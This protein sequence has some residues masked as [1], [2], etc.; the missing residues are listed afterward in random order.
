VRDAGLDVDV[1]QNPMLR[2][3]R[4]RHRP[5][6]L[7]RRAVI[8]PH[9]AAFADGDCDVALDALAH[10]R[11]DPLHVPRVGLDDGTD[12][13][14]LFVDVHVPVVAGQVLVVPHELAGVR[15]QRYGRVAVQIGR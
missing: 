1:L 14:F 15:L 2:V 11:V 8:E 5:Q 4:K 3:V 13:H 7:A 12:E 10:L 6:E 9:A